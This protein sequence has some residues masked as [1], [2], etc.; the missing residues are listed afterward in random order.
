M[1]SLRALGD[2]FLAAVPRAT[3]LAMVHGGF[4]SAWDQAGRIWHG[5]LVRG[6]TLSHYRNMYATG[7]VVCR[8]MPDRAR[9]RLGEEPDPGVGKLSAG[10]FRGAER[11][12]ASPR[13]QGLLEC[14]PARGA[15]LEGNSLDRSHRAQPGRHLVSLELFRLAPERRRARGLG[16]RHGPA[17]SPRGISRDFLFFFA[18]QARPPKHD[19][20]GRRARSRDG[21]TDRRDMKASSGCHDG[22]AGLRASCQASDFRTTWSRT[23]WVLR[24]RFAPPPSPP[25]LLLGM[26]AAIW[27][28]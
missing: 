19:P 7:V 22:G 4:S 26:G 17:D 2:A 16:R 3:V 1:P 14:G 20:F 9:F 25:P 18:G 28:G 8:R 24:N 13:A 15:A 6:C 23:G 5:Q 12:A 11:H 10:A 21:F 27:P